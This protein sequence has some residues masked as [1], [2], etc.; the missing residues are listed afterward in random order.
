MRQAIRKNT[1]T[2]EGPRLHLDEVV[3]IA[4]DHQTRWSQVFEVLDKA[5]HE[6]SGQ[7]QR[8]KEMRTVCPR[9]DGR[10]N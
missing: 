2:V 6:T 10:A 4:G 9:L 7:Q 3:T 5:I 1:E 8:T